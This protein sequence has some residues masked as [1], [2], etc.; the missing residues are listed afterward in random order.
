MITQ[1]LQGE[2]GQELAHLRSQLRRLRSLVWALAGTVVVV[3]VLGASDPPPDVLRARSIELLDSDGTVRVRL[4]AASAGSAGG[5]FLLDE[6]GKAR[7]T[8]TQDE[9]GVRMAMRDADELP[10]IEHAV[11]SDTSA[12]RILNRRA[13]PL[14]VLGADQRRVEVSIRNEDGE[15][16]AGMTSTPT[17]TLIAIE[18]GARHTLAR[19][20]AS[21]DA[22]DISIINRRGNP[23]VQM[24][25][26]QQ[27]TA[28]G[29]MDTTGRVNWS[30]SQQRAT[31][32]E[33]R[34]SVTD[35]FQTVQRQIQDLQ[36]WVQ[37]LIRAF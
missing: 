5:I 22:T 4:A 30:S 2:Q 20:A 36:A 16:L 17:G 29:T 14:V 15:A 7:L 11:S 25:A 3:L 28:L 9:G 26:D 32:D 27:Q 21:V 34:Q 23:L 33:I 8:L 12:I 35:V 37:S 6:A 24:I 19:M 31:N 1:T 18:D 10:L 13:K